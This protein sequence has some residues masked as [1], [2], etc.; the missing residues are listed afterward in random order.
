MDFHDD[1]LNPAEELDVEN[2]DAEDYE[3]DPVIAGAIDNE[4]ARQARSAIPIIAC[5]F[6]PSAMPIRRFR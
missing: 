1:N 4:V 2:Y 3:V 6:C 5:R